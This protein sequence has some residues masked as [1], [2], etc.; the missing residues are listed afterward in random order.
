MEVGVLRC[1]L[2][3]SGITIGELLIRKFEHDP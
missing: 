3:S 1:D 2:Q